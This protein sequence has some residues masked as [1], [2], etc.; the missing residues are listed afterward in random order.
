MVQPTIQLAACSTATDAEPEAATAG[1]TAED[2]VR[3]GRSFAAPLLRDIVKKMG[4][5]VAS[6]KSIVRE[7]LRIL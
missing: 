6:T 1:E 4:E 2:L 3:G 7:D 5:C